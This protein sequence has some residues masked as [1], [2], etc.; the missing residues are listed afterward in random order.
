MESQQRR[1]GLAMVLPAVLTLIA[2]TGYPLFYNVW[3]SF[4]NVNYLAPPIGSFAG[5]SN[6]KTIF[7]NNSFI[8]SLVRT[9]A[10]TAVSVALEVTLSLAVALVLDRSFRGRGVVRAAVFIPWAVPTV[11][12]AELWK[13]MF[14]PQQGFVNYA[15]SLLHLPLAHTTWLNQP[16]TAWTAIFVADAWKNMPFMA[17]LLLAGLQVIPRDVY[18]AARLDGAG[19]WKTFTHITLPLLKP[20]LMVALVFRTLSAFMMFDV[21]YIMTGGGPGDST[22]TLGFLNWQ[23]FLVNSDFGLGGAVSVMLVVIALIIAGIYV[24]VFRIDDEVTQ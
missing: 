4:H 24:R 20:A 7:T 10:F 17:I 2:I 6:Y 19:P 14:D 1:F 9:L 3:N 21:V 8:P 23:A 12:S 22:T 18:Q 5:I 11:V 16:W 13:S 15:L